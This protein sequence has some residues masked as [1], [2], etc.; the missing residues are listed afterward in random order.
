MIAYLLLVHQHPKQFKQLFQS[1]Y[2][3][4]HVYLIHVDKKTDVAV[5]T[6]IEAFLADYGNAHLLERQITNWGGYSLVDA[7]LRGIDDLLKRSMKWQYFINLSGQDLPLKSQTAIRAFLQ[8]HPRTDFMHMMDQRVAQPDTLHRIENYVFETGGDITSVGPTRKNSYLADVTPYV[9]SPGMILSRAFCDFV[10]RHPD[11]DR[12]KTF[13][14]NTWLAD[15]GFFPTVYMNTSYRSTAL[16]PNDMR[17]ADVL[18]PL[19]EALPRSRVFGMAD[20][21]RLQQSEQLFAH[22]FDETMDA[23]IIAHLLQN[24]LQADQVPLPA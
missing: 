20:A 24:L 2:H 14:K 21:A 19:D 18:R 22:K 13:Y 7:T 23:D 3:P 12:F 6:E 11:V 10:V 5:L 4:D 16:V 17:E 9:G 1:L 8:A 15:A